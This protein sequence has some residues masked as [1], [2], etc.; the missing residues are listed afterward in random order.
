MHGKKKKTILKN[1]LE[2]GR[3]KLKNFRDTDFNSLFSISSA[4]REYLP[5]MSHFSNNEIIEKKS[6]EDMF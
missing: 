2:F 6:R 1:S 4:C 3:K 5:G